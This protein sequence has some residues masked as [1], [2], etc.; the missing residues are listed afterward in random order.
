M[1]C[2]NVPPVGY[3][4]GMLV[5]LEPDVLHHGRVVV[6]CDCG[7]VVAMLRADVKYSRSCGCRAGRA[8]TNPYEWSD[9]LNCWVPIL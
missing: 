9:L 6:K 7:N 8:P 2:V 4:H 1:S 5:V 3:R